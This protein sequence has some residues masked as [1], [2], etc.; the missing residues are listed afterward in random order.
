LC[1]KQA[2]KLNVEARGRM[3]VVYMT[4]ESTLI[5]DAP[6]KRKKLLKLKYEIL[7]NS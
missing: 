5:P 7:T 2:R 4:G 1:F 6:G 3:M